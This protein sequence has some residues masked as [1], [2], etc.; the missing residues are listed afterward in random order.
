L[1]ETLSAKTTIPLQHKPP[2]VFPAKTKSITGSQDTLSLIGK[3]GWGECMAVVVR[4][5]YAFI[6]NGSFFQILDITHPANPKLI[7]Q[8]DIGLYIY[9]IKISRHYA[10]LTPYFSII[11]LSDLSNPQVVGKIAL[12]EF[13][14]AIAVSANHV[15]AGNAG[16]D[17]CNIDV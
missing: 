10:Y 14:G 6:G 16:H 5:N 17:V 2:R 1:D 8:V 4:G 13:S 15:Y 11:D 12:P 3:W 7:D 9:G